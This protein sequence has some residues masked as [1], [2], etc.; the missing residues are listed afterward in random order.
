[1]KTASSVTKYKHPALLNLEKLAFVK[2]TLDAH[3]LP[4]QSLKLKSCLIFL[5]KVLE[6]I[7]SYYHTKFYFNIFKSDQFIAAFVYPKVD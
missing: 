1:M 4:R 6:T 3:S 2:E 5:L 7:F